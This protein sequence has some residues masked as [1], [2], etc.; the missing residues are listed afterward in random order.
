MLAQVIVN[1]TTIAAKMAGLGLGLL[2]LDVLYHFD[3]FAF[4]L[5][6]DFFNYALGVKNPV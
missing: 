4:F 6:G 1:S 3:R 2:I 5:W